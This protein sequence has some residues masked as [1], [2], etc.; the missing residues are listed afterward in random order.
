MTNKKIGIFLVLA[1]ALVLFLV[2]PEKSIWIPKC[3]FYVLTGLQCPA[4]GTQ[5]AIHQF[6]HLNFQAAFAYNPFM[7]ISI[8]Y[9]L[10]LATVEWFDPHHKL[11][12]LKTFCHDRRVIY[13]Y[14][15]LFFAWWI[16]RNLI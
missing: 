1:I 9:L 16:I 12:R 4:C 5:R 6:L 3:P 11:Q 15:V 13:T 7:I 2:N 8:P 14:I 10:A